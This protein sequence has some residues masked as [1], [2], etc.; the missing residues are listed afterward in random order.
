LLMAALTGQPGA[1]DHPP[2]SPKLLAV[3]VLAV[4]P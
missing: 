4:I 1:A 3:G 2:I